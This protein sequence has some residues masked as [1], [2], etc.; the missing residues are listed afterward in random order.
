[1]PLI[2]LLGYAASLFVVMSL[3]MSDIK[4]LRYVNLVGCTLFVIYGLLI[5]AYPVVLMNMAAACINIYFL[6]K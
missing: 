6:T 2:E 3:L 5:G 1:M 4:K